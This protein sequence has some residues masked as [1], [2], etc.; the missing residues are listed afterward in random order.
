MAQFLDR[1]IAAKSPALITAYETRIQELEDQRLVLEEK[2]SK[3]EA[4]LPDF[5]KTYKTA[6]KF[7]ENPHK[8]W[9]SERPEDKCTA[10]KLVFTEKLPYDK[11]EGYRTAPIALPFSVLGELEGGQ[12]EMVRGEDQNTIPRYCYL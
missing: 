3:C 10:I 4:K 2:I 5:D 6:I 12:Y 8:I 11:T 1:V 7:L 9:A